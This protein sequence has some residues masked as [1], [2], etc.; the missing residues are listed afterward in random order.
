M[1]HPLDCERV[2]EQW[3]PAHNA[4][5]VERKVGVARQARSLSVEITQLEAPAAG[6]PAGTFAGYAIEPAFNIAGEREVGRT[7]S[8][9][10]PAIADSVIEPFRQHE[11]NPF[12][13]SSAG[14]QFLPFVDPGKLL[15]VPMLAVAD[16]GSNDRRLQAAQCALEQLV[17]TRACCSPN[18]GEQPTRREAEEP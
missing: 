18:C 2:P 17:L 13:A 3:L 12:A 8:E 16:G 7:N 9:G 1:G 10:E 6:L 5:N 4:A 14:H 15:A 11:L